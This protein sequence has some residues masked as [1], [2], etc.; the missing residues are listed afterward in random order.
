MATE[1]LH[2]SRSRGEA[3]LNKGH[4]VSDPA[5]WYKDAVIYQVNVRSYYDS[6]ND[7]IGDLAGLTQRLDYIQSLNVTAIWLLPFFESPLRDGGYDI[8]DYLN[9][10]PIYGSVQ[11]FKKLLKAAHDRDIKVITELVINHTSD[12]HEWFQRSRKAKPGSKWRDFYVW[13]DNPNGYPD[14]RIIFQD[15][16]TSNWTWDP[17]AQ[18]YFWHRFYH[19]Q[20]DLNFENPAVRRA[21]VDVLDYWLQMG[22]DGLRLDAVPYL[23]EEEGT[24]CENLPRTHAYLRELRQHV[25]TRH[26]NKMLLAEANQ[27]PEDAAEYF[28]HGDEC[29]MNFHFP[30]MPRLFMSVESEDSFP[31]IDILEQTPEL[32]DGCQWAIFLRNHDELTLEMV[33]E[34]ERLRMYR[35]YATDP[36]ARINLGIRRRLAPLLA[37]NRNKIELMNALLFSLPGT[38]IIYYGDEIG[39]GDNFFLGDRDGVRTPMQWNGN[40]NADFSHCNPHKLFL[41]IITDPEYHY[42]LCNVDRAHSSPH[43][44]LW[45]M[46]RLIALR[47]QHR[48][49]GHGTVKLL[50]ADNKKVLAFL[51]EDETETLL[52]VANLSR[53]S[54]CVQ[55]DLSEYEGNVPIE[56]CGRTQFPRITDRPYDLSLNPYGYYW[57]QLAS[58][59]EADQGHSIFEL[60]ACI[61]TEKWDE[62][63]CG[64]SLRIIQNALARYL[65]S[66]R[67]FAGKARTI[68]S[69]ELV[70][71]FDVRAHQPGSSQADEEAAGESKFPLWLMIIRV[72]YVEGESELYSIPL[73]IS[74]EEQEDELLLDSAQCLIATIQRTCDHRSYLLHESIHDPEI[75]SFLT[76]GTTGRRK[77]RGHH[78]ILEAQPGK[79][80]KVTNGAV[81]S[82]QILGVEQSNSSAIVNERYIAKTFRRLAPGTNP[83]VE[84]GRFLGDGTPI[85][86]PKLAAAWE[87]QTPQSENYTLAVLHEYV[88][89]EGD[90]WAYSLDE[91]RLFLE[92]VQTIEHPHEA[93]DDSSYQEF[94]TLDTSWLT[95]SCKVGSSIELPPQ[96]H[97]LMGRYLPSMQILGERTAEM[98]LALATPAGNASFQPEP[99]NKLYQRGLFQS[100]RAQ[101]QRS[102]ELLKQRLPMLSEDSQSPAEK[103]LARRDLISAQFQELL[104]RPLQGQRIRCH[105]DFHLG[106]VLFTG[107]DFYI[108][109]FEGEPDRPIGERR[110][111]RSPLRDVASLLR[112]FHYVAY[113]AQQEYEADF[114][115]QQ[116]VGHWLD[117]WQTWASSVFWQSYQS[118]IAAGN[119]LPKSADDQCL[120]LQ[121]FML[122]K[123]LREL[124][125]ELNNRPTWVDV[126]LTGILKLTCE[127]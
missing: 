66:K 116:N 39:M 58:Y 42:S 82:V 115:S 24:N 14:A 57:F 99:F 95:N 21:I 118:T 11:D 38:P 106:Q 47:K 62:L 36:Q 70:D 23:F 32:P 88:P 85:H 97:G 26:N 46:R 125:Y 94:R 63:F 40:V 61:I 22:V 20:P 54:Q 109:D 119:L 96:A 81:Y 41:P 5:R 76:T 10:N 114:G 1:I 110:I 104:S 4:V 50:S 2:P 90:A 64:G 80:V 48:A 126:P 92:R 67:W 72:N 121:L 9:I 87:Y 86:T 91:V 100:M 107:S 35:H 45:W 78:G 43:S 111:K 79:I 12:Q 27:W 102:L 31:I 71:L 123:S 120:L 30:L 124:T 15:F 103:V 108:I 37:N 105:G 98:H 8:S 60:P 33:T 113:Q 19:H 127:S 16:E 56:L 25:D 55:L 117:M 44:L 17:V 3:V 89:N 84:I 29:H 18:A 53:F 73:G 28:G 68:H 75:W 122:E 49:F 77:V 69:I 51:R 59:T 112:S 6:N 101:T 83:D 34:E 7:G 65:N 13:S 52:V 93:A 74:A